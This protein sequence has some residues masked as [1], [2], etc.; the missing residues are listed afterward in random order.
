MI[1]KETKIPNLYDGSVRSD[2]YD[3][4]YVMK[5]NKRLKSLITPGIVRP[6]EPNEVLIEIF[7]GNNL[8]ISNPIF[9]YWI[10]SKCY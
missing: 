5:G 9:I 10:L 4:S 2:S 8:L 3:E 6:N 7:A 1:G